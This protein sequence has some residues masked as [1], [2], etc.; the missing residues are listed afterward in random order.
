MQIEKG[1]FRRW[2]NFSRD[3]KIS[4]KLHRYTSEEYQEIIGELRD[5]VWSSTTLKELDARILRLREKF[6]VH[7]SMDWYDEMAKDHPDFPTNS[8]I[9]TTLM[10]FNKELARRSGNTFE[11]IR[12]FG[13]FNDLGDLEDLLP[14]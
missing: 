13:G 7:R 9:V 12:A 8:Y 3:F 6:K 5:T 11:E 1:V 2:F 10:E 14:E 4:E